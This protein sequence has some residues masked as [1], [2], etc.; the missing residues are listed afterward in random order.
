MHTRAR[1][2]NDAGAPPRHPR[3]PHTH[4]WRPTGTRTRTHTATPAAAGTRVRTPSRR[5][6][7]D[8]C[9]A[10]IVRAD[11]ATPTRCVAG[12]HAQMAARHHPM[13]I[14]V[15][16]LL[17][18]VVAVALTTIV[19]TAVLGAPWAPTF[20]SDGSPAM[21]RHA[22][23]MADSEA[24]RLR[25]RAAANAAAAT[26]VA[27]DLG[28]PYAAPRAQFPA[29][30]E[31]TVDVRPPTDADY[32]A[33]VRKVAALATAGPVAPDALKTALD[34]HRFVADV[35]GVHV[36]VARPPHAP[37]LVHAAELSQASRRAL[38]ALEHLTGEVHYPKRTPR[39]E[40][41]AA[42]RT[43]R[44]GDQPSAGPSTGPTLVPPPQCRAGG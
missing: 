4:T 10:Y 13:E 37:G 11:S 43:V 44:P 16:V 3:H 30:A 15:W 17:L 18:V 33:A 26:R 5:G 22:L 36:V 21:V 27:R 31:P 29:P 28:M 12:S 9:D 38:A 2:L 19:L 24:P 20:D 8:R 6:D 40:S 25:R 1:T 41:V 39:K 42:S 23:R 14:T 32:E 35:G 34:G 7:F